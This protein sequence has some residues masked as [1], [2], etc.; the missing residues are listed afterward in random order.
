MASERDEGLAALRRGAFDTAVVLLESA[1][2]Q[3]PDDFWAHLYLGGSYHQ[4]HRSDE[5]IRTLRLAVRLQP[6]NAQ[7]HYNLAIAL[8]RAGSQEEAVREVQSA[9]TVQPDYPLAQQALQRLNPPVSDSSM[10][11]PVP[12]PSFPVT[13]S[14]A[15]VFPPSAGVR[16]SSASGPFQLDDLPTR[17]PP[18][19]P[20]QAP[21]LNDYDPART[22]QGTPSSSATATT[23]AYNPAPP[24]LP[25]SNTGYGAPIPP[26]SAGYSQ[27]TLYGQP[28]PAYRSPSYPAPLAP[29]PSQGYSYAPTASGAPPWNEDSFSVGQGFSDWLQI[30]I[31]PLTFFQGQQGREGFLAPL[32]MAMAYALALTAALTLMGFIM[33]GPLMLIAIFFLLF[34]VV[35]GYVAVLTLWAAMA[36]LIHGI[37]KLFGN[38]A[39]FAGSFRAVVYAQAP[40]ITLAALAFLLTPVLSTRAIPTTAAVPQA[41]IVTVQFSP[42]SSDG[43]SADGNRLPDTQGNFSPHHAFPGAAS[44]SGNPFA[45]RTQS[46]LLGLLNIFGLIWSVSLLGIAIHHIQ[47]IPVG[48]AI[49]TLLIS[50]GLAFAVCVF[51]G[52]L[53]L[54]TVLGAMH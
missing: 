43:S 41:R 5:A 11:A 26:Q 14:L 33:A 4:L 35:I 47:K 39:S 27:P 30:L 7:A 49:G 21:T 25:G 45:A 3:D 13:P 31:S 42:P 50:V 19:S 38:S 36:G 28:P 23:S 17:T 8:E 54:S 6:G 16:D 10:E 29:Y 44:S 1:C 32:S 9:L 37:G 53:F 46:P 51:L 15:T 48:G 20:P 2:R 18:A 24:P 40:G 52:Y 34:F 12:S 22:I